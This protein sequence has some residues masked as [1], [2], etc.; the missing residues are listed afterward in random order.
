VNS[1]NAISRMEA[2]LRGSMSMGA[3]K[4]ESGTGYV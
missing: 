4:D 1:E 2:V 3:E